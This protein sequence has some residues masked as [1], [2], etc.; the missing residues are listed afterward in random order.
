MEGKVLADEYDFGGNLIVIIIKFI[1][2]HIT[3][4]SNLCDILHKCDPS[5][6]NQPVVIIYKFLFSKLSFLL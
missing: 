4:F 2:E 1:R 6:Q 5:H 3:T